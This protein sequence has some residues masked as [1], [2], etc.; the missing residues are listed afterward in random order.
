MALVVNGKSDGHARGDAGTMV[1]GG[2]IGAALH[3]D[4]RTALVVGLGTG[5]SAGWLAGVPSIER[6]DVVELERA[7]L[8]VVRVSAAVNRN[9][10]ADPKVH[11][12][13]NDAREVLLTTSR[14]YDVIFSEPSPLSRV[15]LTKRAVTGLSRE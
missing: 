8:E 3:P 15:R 10:L 12:T 13:I 14:R 11:I 7:V 4:P 2:L 5:C 1:M 9:V 6:V